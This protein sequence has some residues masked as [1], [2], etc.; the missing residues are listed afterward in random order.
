[1]ARN[2]TSRK[3]VVVILLCAIFTFTSASEITYDGSSLM[4]DGERK[5]IL[6]GSIHYPRSTAQVSAFSFKSSYY[7]CYF[8]WLIYFNFLMHTLNLYYMLYRC[9]HPLFIK[10]KKVASMPLKLTFFGMLMSLLI[11][12]C[13]YFHN[14]LSYVLIIYKCT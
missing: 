7:Y 8:I 3:A 14:F 13:H 4:I 10:R 1:M 12:R 9:G 11:V 2:M 6:S 5:L